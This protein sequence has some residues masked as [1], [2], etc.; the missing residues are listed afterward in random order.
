M[1]AAKWSPRRAM[2]RSRWSIPATLGSGR[3]AS[4]VGISPPPKPFEQFRRSGAIGRGYEFELPWPDAAPQNKKLRIVCPLRHARWPQ[5]DQPRCRSASTRRR[6]GQALA[7]RA[8]PGRVGD[9]LGWPLVPIRRGSAFARRAVSSHGARDPSA[10]ATAKRRLSAA[11]G[12]AGGNGTATWTRRIERSNSARLPIDET[13]GPA[14]APATGPSRSPAAVTAGR[15]GHRIADRGSA[16]RRCVAHQCTR[17]PGLA[18]WSGLSRKI[19]LP[20]APA[21][22]TMPSLRPNGHLPRLQVG[23]HNDQPAD[24]LG[25]FVGALDAGENRAAARRRPG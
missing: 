5:T 25:R 12:A 23:D 3:P 6:C 19:S 24:Q 11:A 7:Q 20:P 17:W 9:F 8:A 21:A 16:S 2:S 1:R 13:D 15:L 4:P 10:R 14:S 22:T 18:R